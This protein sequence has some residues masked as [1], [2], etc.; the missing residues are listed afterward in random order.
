M[1]EQLSEP[2]K[3][4]NSPV[5]TI[6]IIVVSIALVLTGA[7]VPQELIQPAT[8]GLDAEVLAGETSVVEDAFRAMRQDFAYGIGRV[9]VFQRLEFRIQL[10][11][12]R[13]WRHGQM[14]V[15][16]VDDLLA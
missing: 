3:K 11:I 9:F 2:K 5:T 16:V 12:Q 1:N 13:H 8:D 7:L 15:H 10:G 6:I 14:Q 4:G